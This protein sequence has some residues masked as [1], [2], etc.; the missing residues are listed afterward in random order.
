MT[1]ISNFIMKKNVAIGAKPKKKQ[2]PI[3]INSNPCAN[4]F[5]FSNQIN[6]IASSYL[7]MGQKIQISK[8]LKNSKIIQVN[9]NSAGNYYTLNSKDS[10]QIS[11]SVGNSVLN[12]YQSNNVSENNGINFNNF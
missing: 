3:N 6:P 8:N 7:S 1:T 2:I 10:K 5:L 11:G 12:N 9:T 4:K